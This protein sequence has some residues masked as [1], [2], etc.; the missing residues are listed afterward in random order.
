MS[1]GGS[2]AINQVAVGNGT[3]TIDGSSNFTYDGSTFIMNGNVVFSQAT[4]TT[5]ASNFVGTDSST[6]GGALLIRSGAGWNSDGT[7]VATNG[8][9]FTIFAGSGGNGYDVTNI[10]GSGGSTFIIGGPGGHFGGIGGLVSCTGGNGA[11]ADDVVGIIGAMGGYV[12]V[13]GGSGGTG[14]ISNV[15]GNGGH[16]ALSGGPAGLFGLLPGSAVVIG[17]HGNYANDTIGLDAIAGANAF[18]KGGTGGVGDNARSGADGG[19]VEIF[20]GIAGEGS[21]ASPPSN[22]GNGGNVIIQAARAGKVYG[23]DSLVG[24]YGNTGII[25]LLGATAYDADEDNL[26]PASIGGN[27][28]ILA[29]HGGNG[30][31]SFSG[32]DGG[33][34]TIYAGNAG[35]DGGSGA[36]NPGSVKIAHATDK[37][38]FFAV[39]PVGQPQTTGTTTGF[40]A[41]SGTGMNNDSTSTGGSGSAAYT[42]GDVILALKQLG[43]LKA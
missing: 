10:G 7:A 31:T 40:T 16:V 41:G 17:G 35:T 33:N 18:L 5:L 2:I 3:D 15:G 14:T 11:D 1:I 22:S 25:A 29:A 21:N 24:S 26:I 38:A 8:G 12:S 37:M 20:G 42:F 39:T 30:T 19:S 13:G 36:G 43:L 23:V 32:S 4:S 6:V 27:I 28:E 34:I 9:D